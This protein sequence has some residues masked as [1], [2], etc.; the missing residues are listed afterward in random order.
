MSA[1]V[2]FAVLYRW[3]VDP[4]REEEF[5][6]AWAS[7]TEAI[8]RECGGLGSRLHRLDG[9]GQW[10]AYAQWPSRESWEAAREADS[11]DPESTAA[12]GR[13]VLESFPPLLMVPERDLLA[14]A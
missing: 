12:L 4:A 13:A 5:I 11:P 6:A 3:R 9:D 8:A 7:L 1:K 2:G 10:A 14:G